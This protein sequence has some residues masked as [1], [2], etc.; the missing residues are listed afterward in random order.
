MIGFRVWMR[1]SENTSRVR[2]EGNDN[3]RWLIRRLNQSFIFKSSEPLREQPDTLCFIF[4]VP[5]SSQVSRSFFKKLLSSIPEV[6][7]LAETA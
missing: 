6:T 3:A 4:D 1:S 2:V 7:L 5:D